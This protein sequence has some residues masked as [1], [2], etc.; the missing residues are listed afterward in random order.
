MQATSNTQAWSASVLDDCHQLV[1][2]HISALL[3][4]MFGNSDIAFQEFIDRA[5]SSAS[6]IRFMEAMNVI[7]TNRSR[8]EEVFKR[9]L[10]NGFREFCLLQYAG[11]QEAV[12]HAEPL[13][14][15]SKEDTDIQVALQNMAAS[16]SS[17][18][19]RA[20]YAIRQRLS[21]LNNGIKLDE[22]QIPGGPHALSEA[23][24]Q[25]AQ[26]LVL[27]HEIRLIVYMLFD[28]F[29][30]SKAAV[31]YEDY[32]RRL[33]DAGLLPNLKYE[34]H[35]HPVADTRRRA[36]DSG[37]IAQGNAGSGHVDDGADI[38]LG[39]EL[40]NNILKLLSRRDHTNAGPDAAGAA[41]D[42]LP[43]TA[44]VSAIHQLQL[45]RHSD[46]P[47]PAQRP[48]APVSAQQQQQHVET[49]LAQL[50]DERDQLFTGIDRRRLPAADTNVIDL[51][52]MM[53]EYLLNDADLP[54]V[55]KA[56]L[57]RLHT[58][59][60]KAAIIDKSLFTNSRHPAHEL[61]NVL[62]AAG[63]TWVFED[64]LTRGIFPTMRKVVQRIIEEFESNIEIF[65]ELL[66]L[67]HSSIRDLENRATAIEQRTRQAAAGREKLELA[68]NCAARAIET[69]VSGRAVPEELLGIL[70]D[71]WID[72]LMFIYLR[73]PES[74]YSTA[75]SLANQIIGD[76]IWSVEPRTTAEA[77]D[78]LRAK[79][80]DLR[81]KIERAFERLDAYGASDNDAQLAVISRL[82]DAALET[83]PA[84]PTATTAPDER[85]PYPLGAHEAAG[86]TATDT[87]AAA[88]NTPDSGPVPRAA[89]E[90]AGSETGTADEQPPDTAPLAAAGRVDTAAPA[91]AADEAPTAPEQFSP[92]MRQAL[93]V[94]DNL[95]FGT[96][97]TFCP[98]EDAT[99]VRLKLSWFSQLSGNYMFVDSM[100][101]KAAVKE[102]IE[103]ASLLADGQAR[104]LSDEQQTFVQRA[105]LAVRRILTG[106]IKTGT[107]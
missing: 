91:A 10:D 8:M 38:S 101:I 100:G 6:Q 89:A 25:A 33:L 69:C 19:G 61:L 17:G 2:T 32:N 94:V 68:R 71:T 79:L 93:E 7:N 20:L 27:D 37:N 83:P 73:E 22:E 43:R 23:F 70:R 54:S 40:F 67:C 21:V 4:K 14:L 63:T 99:P 102:R 59:Y 88:G 81:H 105:M 66:E 78:E 75:W 5:Q 84:A 9:Q 18:A 24:H 95:A 72:K 41:A 50:S 31:M 60:L 86:V 57:S 96:W 80:P 49:M 51:V 87:G 52:G 48:R 98:G 3:K 45:K 11:R 107:R 44:V 1:L 46:P 104:I 65:D 77:R 76:I 28:K 58:P 36:S 55:A 29:V 106:E 42:P 97:F 92:G 15:V 90:P 74:Q 103:L 53:F 26:E 30:L 56:E 12:R 34:V 62:A 35:R 13:S 64:D 16:A 85:S 47:E 39:D 82:Q